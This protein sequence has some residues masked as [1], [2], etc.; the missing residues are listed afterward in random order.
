MSTEKKEEV[1]SVQEVDFDLNDLLA[2]PGAEAV[3]LPEEATGEK[4][5]SLFAPMTTDTTFL[6]KPE[7]K[8]T[9]SRTEEHDAE[10]EDPINDSED[11]IADPLAQPD[12]FSDDDDKNKGG[13]PT[14]LV[15]AA[16]KLIDKGTLMPFEDE[17]KI[18]DYT[19][20]DFQELV[21]A[22]MAQYQE[23]AGNQVA[24][25]FFQSLPQEMQQAYEY[26]ASGGQDMK[27]MFSALSASTEMRDLDITKEAGQKYAIRAYLQATNYGT[28]D[29]IEDEIY[30]YEDRGDLEKKAKQFKPKLDNMQQQIVNDRVAQQA[31]Q[32]KQRQNQSQKYIDSVYTT[33]EQGKLGSIDLDNKTQEMLYAGL[34]QSNYPSISGKQT[35]ML[36]H[37]LEKYQWVEPRHDL[38][39]EALWLLADPDGYKQTIGGTIQKEE[40]KKTLR[41]L[42]TE[43][44][45]KT[46]TTVQDEEPQATGRKRTGLQRPKRSFFG[47]S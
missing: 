18:E 19:A 45:A 5:K 34:V 14:A 16:K 30:S 10:A 20:E 23:K 11:P 9:V 39:A 8:T 28:P 37:L 1:T 26:M 44:S 25:Q 42:K 21:E 17:K 36:G 43:Q 12:T 46:A 32:Q 3:M 7:A 41:T 4:K 13:R 38:I 47:R 31:Q 29:E 15:S 40:T 27:G 24:E 6:D 33:L 35:N 2:I 22:N